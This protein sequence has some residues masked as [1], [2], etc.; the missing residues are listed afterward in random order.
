MIFDTLDSADKGRRCQYYHPI[1]GA[2]EAPL[3][4]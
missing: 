2:F 3:L 1:E 4:L